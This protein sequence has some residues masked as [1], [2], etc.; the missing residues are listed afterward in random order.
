MQKDTLMVNSEA[1]TA[2]M[3]P[4]RPKMRLWLKACAHCSLCAESCFLYTT[5]GRDPKYIPSHKFIHSIGILYKSKGRVDRKCLEE[6]GEIVWYRCVLCMR[7]YCPFGIDI[8]AMIALARKIC[9]TQDIYR[10]YDVD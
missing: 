2:L 8:P 1:I 6:I 7:C 4:E 10:K 9:R 5:R 3:A